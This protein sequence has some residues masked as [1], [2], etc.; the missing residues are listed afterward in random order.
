MRLRETGIAFMDVQDLESRRLLRSASLRVHSAFDS[1]LAEM[2]VQAGSVQKIAIQIWTARTPP[3]ALPDRLTRSDPLLVVDTAAS[4][5][6]FGNLT[7]DDRAHTLLDFHADHIADLARRYAWN[8]AAIEDIREAC[9]RANVV[10]S[11]RKEQVDPT[12][13]Y[14]VTASGHVD[15][16]GIRIHVEIKETAGGAVVASADRTLHGDYWTM[17]DRL[18]SL[19]WNGDGEAILEGNPRWVKR[20]PA[21]I[22]KP[23][24]IS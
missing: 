15:D 18:H 6:S 19:T 20:P 21:V 17:L 10:A 3:M 16:A 13:T 1:F 8:G 23:D 9:H 7:A 22:L 5:E 12:G 4:V 11:T 2:P 24:R 14:R